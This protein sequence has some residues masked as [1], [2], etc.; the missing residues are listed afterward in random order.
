MMCQTMGRYPM[1]TM[2]LGMVSEN[3]R[4]RIP[5]P[6]QN[7]TTFIAVLAK[8]QTLERPHLDVSDL[9]GPRETQRVDDYG[10]NVTRLHQILGSIGS[11][12][13]LMYAFLQWRRRAS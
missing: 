1:F 5:K 4:S 8:L 7:R 9:G 10:S 3:S 12:L 6:P 13:Y 11:M 2:G